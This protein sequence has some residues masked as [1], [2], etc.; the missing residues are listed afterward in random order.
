MIIFA[1]F[2][3]FFYP[4]VIVYLISYS[5]SLIWTFL[6]QMSM[7]YGMEMSVIV[8]SFYLIVSLILFDK[9]YRNFG[10]EGLKSDRRK[11]HFLAII[12]NILLF[13]NAFS[14]LWG[15]YPLDINQC[16][17]S[18]YINFV[19]AF[20]YK[21][22]CYLHLFKRTMVLS[23]SKKINS[24]CYIG[25]VL[26][27]GNMCYGFFTIT[28][29]SIDVSYGQCYFLLNGNYY[30]Q[31][32][33]IDLSLVLL[34]LVVEVFLYYNYFEN[35]RKTI[36]KLS[37]SEKGK[38][39]RTFIV[40]IFPF[41]FFILESASSIMYYNS[42]TPQEWWNASYLFVAMFSIQ[43]LFPILMDKDY[44]KLLFIWENNFYF[45]KNKT[46]N[47]GTEL[48]SPTNKETNI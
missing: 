38:Y 7:F 29:L 45:V 25:M 17:S 41:L 19:T 24:F 10:I 40:I 23:I 16:S 3:L 31:Q 6:P 11:L 33:I 35:K 34:F 46:T 32:I 9:N 30:Y 44:K 4:L 14:Q 12:T 39:L 1:D 13:L 47:A 18:T 21:Y 27:F 37:D 42:T 2:L 26:F 20:L 22:C 15:C 8:Y 28:T 48:S 36:G 5:N 43:S